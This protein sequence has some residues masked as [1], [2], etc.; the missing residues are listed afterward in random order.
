MR[1]VFTV[2][3]DSAAFT[4]RV[5]KSTVSK[6]AFVSPAY[7]HCDNGPASIPMRSIVKPSPFKKPTSVAGSLPIFAS[8]TILPLAST[9]QTLDSS[10]DTSI[11][12]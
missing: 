12:A 2:I 7:S 3:A 11:P 10:K 1:S 6:P 8:L 5:S 9:M 4:C